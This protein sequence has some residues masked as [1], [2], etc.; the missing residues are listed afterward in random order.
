MN[1]IVRQNIVHIFDNDSPLSAFIIDINN[2]GYVLI[3]DA[4]RISQ[5]KYLSIRMV[6]SV[7]FLSFACYHAELVSIRRING[8]GN[9]SGKKEE[10]CVQK[11]LMILEINSCT[12]MTDKNTQERV[13][14]S[15]LKNDS[16]RFEHIAYHTLLA[17]I[18]F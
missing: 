4:L 7:I 5:R 8:I 6:C 2:S 13:S 17:V 1:E 10:V 12:S 18:V 3:V 9:Q 11:M 16:N 15:Q 14:K